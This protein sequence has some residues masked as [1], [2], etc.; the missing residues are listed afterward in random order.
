MPKRFCSCV[1]L[2]YTRSEL[3]S[4]A[5][6]I[7]GHNFVQNT[8]AI[9]YNDCAHVRTPPKV[10]LPVDLHFLPHAS[11]A[12][13]LVS[14]LTLHLSMSI[15]NRTSNQTLALKRKKM[16]LARVEWLPVTSRSHVTSQTDKCKIS[17]M[18]PLCKALTLRGQ[19]KAEAVS[20]TGQFKERQPVLVS[21]M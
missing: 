15:D 12:P 6:S 7:R 21:Y 1:C 11:N 18:I 13:S 3:A 17:I 19:A 4:L 2:L 16:F 8:R 14:R 20:K 5:P 9:I 10:S